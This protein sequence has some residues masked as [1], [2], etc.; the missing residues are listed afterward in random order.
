MCTF[1]NDLTFFKLSRI[2]LFLILGGNLLDNKKKV[3]IIPPNPQLLINKTKVA[4]YCR[5][6]TSHPSQIESLNNQINYYKSLVNT[7]YNWSLVD[8]YFDVKSGKNSSDRRDFQRLLTD[9]ENEKIDLIITKSISRFGRNTADT[10]SVL[11]RLR[12]LRIDV[13]FE[14]ENLHLFDTAQ[15]FLINILQ[16]LAQADSESRSKNI[17][18]G[19]TY[20]AKNGT[21]KLFDRKCYGYTN[22]INGSII[23]NE[24]EA[25][26]VKEIFN[27]YLN[28]FSLN[29]IVK[30]LSYRNIN[31]PTGKSNWPKGTIDAL[32]SNEKYIGNVI[33]GKSI[34]DDFP[35]NTRRLNKGS[36]DKYIAFENHPSII[37]KEIFEMVQEEK[38]KRSNI[39]IDNGERK[40]KSTHYS[41]KFISSND[42]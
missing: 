20:K 6:S 4:I 36:G 28:G 3:T 24:S 9:C 21:C 16:G 13:F 37:S 29:A 5:V 11:N 10:L 27:L 14:N 30:E 19:I 12:I 17:K 18:L 25:I 34:S 22:D 26:V 39:F 2:L 15:Q 31:S 7:N 1:K 33:I 42:V 40:R 32:L 35:Y 8:T 41:M 23:I 38:K